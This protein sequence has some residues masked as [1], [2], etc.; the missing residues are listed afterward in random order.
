MSK[1]KSKKLAK[2]E[3]KDYADFEV[4][5][6]ELK[7]EKTKEEQVIDLVNNIFNYK[8]KKFTFIRAEKEIFFKG[9][10]IAEFL[11]YKDTKSAIQDHVREKY[12]M[13]LSELTKF[14]GGVLLPLNIGGCKISTL[15]W[16]EKNTIYISQPGVISLIVK[17]ACPK[18]KHFKIFFLIKLYLL[19]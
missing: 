11:E 18:Q 17:V 8:N 14:G 13:T 7:K 2:V 15:T 4:E 6:I 9:K 19:F 12:K 16:N 10:E 1:T 5:I 3:E